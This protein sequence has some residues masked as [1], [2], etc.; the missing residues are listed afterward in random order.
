[1]ALAYDFRED[2]DVRSVDVLLT[3]CHCGREKIATSFEIDYSP[4]AE[5]ISK[6]LDPIEQPWLKAKQCQ[7]TAYWQPADAERFASYL[8]GTLGALMY[9]AVDDMEECRIQ[10]ITFH[11][12]L[13]YDLYFTNIPAAVP[14]RSRDP[15]RAA[16]LLRLASPFRI[17]CPGGFALLHYVEYAEEILW[18]SEVRR[19]PQLF[20]SFAAQARQWLNQNYSSERGRN[21]ADHPMEYQRIISL[22]RREGGSPSRAL[23]E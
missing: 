2:G 1:V 4:T 20:L 15:Q 16:P 21:T 19:Q 13:E 17:A 3:C 5:L 18:D 23:P 12:E 9:R 14:I 22:L 10:S 6:P 11:P 7:I 8:T